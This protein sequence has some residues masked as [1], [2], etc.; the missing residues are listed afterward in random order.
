MWAPAWAH[1]SAISYQ[2]VI[3]VNR[4]LKIE[5]GP[6]DRVYSVLIENSW[7]WNEEI[8]VGGHRTRD[9]GV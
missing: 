3:S 8:C 9:V 6:V 1:I 4:D 2:S 7:S 5:T